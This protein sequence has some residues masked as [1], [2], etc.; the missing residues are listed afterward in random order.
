MERLVVARPETPFRKRVSA[1]SM[2]R[3]G[4]LGDVNSQALIGK[5]AFERQRFVHP[6]FWTTFALFCLSLI[7]L[8]YLPD[9]VSFKIRGTVNLAY[10]IALAQ[11]AITFIAAAAYSWWARHVIDPLAAEARLT[12]AAELAG[13]SQ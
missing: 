8:A 9:V 10:L 13:R 4:A 1:R 6:L 12:L 7:A 11:F 2:L 3:A 5:I